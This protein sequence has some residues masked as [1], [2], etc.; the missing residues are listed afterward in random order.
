MASV[1]GDVELELTIGTDGAVRAVTAKSGNG[2]L[3]GPTVDALRKWTFSPCT[4]T[5]GECRYSMS[6]HFLLR[7]GPI[8]ISQCHTTFQF[9]VNGVA[10]VESQ[11]A[12]AIVD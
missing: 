9:D 6:I 5:T 11:L 2:L 8:D 1:Q 7:G 12:K 3:V 4:D 10:V